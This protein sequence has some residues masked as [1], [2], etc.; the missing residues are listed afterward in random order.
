MTNDLRALIATQ[1]EHPLPPVVAACASYLRDHFGSSTFGI[2]FYGAGLRSPIADDTLLD[3]YAIVED[4]RVALRGVIT[5][6]AAMILPPN[7]YLI[8]APAAA[9]VIRAKVAVISRRD[10]MQGMA[11]FSS[12]LWGR[13]AQ[14]TAIAFA[15]DASAHDALIGALASAARTLVA[16]TLPLMRGAFTARELWRRGL[17]ECYGAELR[18]ELSRAPELVDAGRAHFEAVT[19]AILGPP[20]A[21]DLYP[22]PAQANPKRAEVVWAWRR[23]WG[24]TTNLLRLMKAAF[25]FTGGLDYAVAKI[26]RHTGVVVE[27]SDADR[28]HPL[29]AGFRVFLEARRRG[30][31][32]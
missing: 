1:A 4:P 9:G 27:I 17:E 25:T 14:P 19:T 24:K 7:V 30:G 8:E 18:P 10:F 22:M 28:R 5:G 32:R 23:R 12:H 15:R 21:H 2:L 20:G 13:F 3:F 29:I 6:T 11:A 26:A 31:V 16:Q